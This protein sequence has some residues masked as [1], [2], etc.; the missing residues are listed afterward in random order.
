MAYDTVADRAAARAAI[1][2]IVTERLKAGGF[3]VVGSEETEKF[4][5]RAA[6]DVG[7][8]FDPVTGDID[9]ARFKTVRDAVHRDLGKERDVD[10]ILYLSISPVVLY[11]PGSTVTYCGTTTGEPLY[12]PPSAAPWSELPTLALVL[13]LNAG[14]FD[15]AGRE[16]YGIRHCLDAAETYAE[17]SRAVRP[18]AQRLRQHA[19]IV[20]A[21][22]ATVGPLADAG[23]PGG[24]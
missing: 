4:W 16:L 17:Q 21:V 12:W 7:A 10:A 15:I 22:E 23:S 8:V 3:A 18:I 5:R 9:E 6:G 13:C 19:R 2:P 20:E 1:E 11:L 24:K 14:L